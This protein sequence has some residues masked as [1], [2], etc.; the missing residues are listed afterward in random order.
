MSTKLG[1]ERIRTFIVNHWED[2]EDAFDR[3]DN[4]K[5]QCMIM[6]K[7]MEFDIPKMSSV[8]VK[9]E[10]E[11]PDWMKKIDDMRKK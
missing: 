10:T 4:P 8:E 6:L 5:D 7:L 3:I 1:K 11:S 9:G 2:F